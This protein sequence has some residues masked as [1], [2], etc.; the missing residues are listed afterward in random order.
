MR[1]LS[2]KERKWDQVCRT[3]LTHSCALLVRLDALE[4]RG[5][6][7]LESISLGKEWREI[8]LVYIEERCQNERYVE[9]R[10]CCPWL[11]PRDA[12]LNVGANG[13][14]MT[15]SFTTYVGSHGPV[16]NWFGIRRIFC[17]REFNSCAPKRRALFELFHIAIPNRD[18]SGA[19]GLHGSRGFRDAKCLADGQGVQDTHSWRPDFSRRTRFR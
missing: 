14:I 2:L 16:A 9:L 18:G 17:C 12:C 13:G 15:A 3:E 1:D 7:L 6:I 10:I 5:K 4:R 11:Q 19:A 8:W